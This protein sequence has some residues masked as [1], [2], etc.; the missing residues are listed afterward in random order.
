MTGDFMLRTV[1]DFD[2]KLAMKE[3]FKKLAKTDL[4]L[5]EVRSRW[6]GLLQI[7]QVP[8]PETFWPRFVLFP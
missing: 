3:F 8:E 1:E 7:G 6:K 2:W 5:V 4:D